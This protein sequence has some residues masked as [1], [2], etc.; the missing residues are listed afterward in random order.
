LELRLT[1]MPFVE[2]I[3]ADFKFR[4]RSV[5]RFILLAFFMIT[6]LFANE[7]EDKL[8]ADANRFYEQAEE[9]IRKGSHGDAAVLFKASLDMLKRLQY[10]YPT[11]NSVV[12][13]NRLNSCTQRVSDSEALILQSIQNLSK[14]E[15]ME[16][17]KTTQIA[18]AKFSKA[19]MILYDDLNRTKLE[20][21]TKN[22]SLTEAREAAGMRV[23]DKAHLDKLTFENL[24][25]RKSLRDK[26]VQ[27]LS[28]SSDDATVAVNAEVNAE[29]NE[30]ILKYKKLQK[31]FIDKENKLKLEKSNLAGK[32]KT[33]SLKL[34]SLR[35]KELGF[36]KNLAAMELLKDR[37]QTSSK[38]EKALVQKLQVE[39]K[40]S[41]EKLSLALSR[42]KSSKE[43]EAEMVNSITALKKNGGNS[44]MVANLTERNDELLK[45]NSELEKQSID[46]LAKARNLSNEYG[47]AE[48]ALKAQIEG[49]KSSSKENSLLK[50]KVKKSEAELK[51][52]SQAFRA[53]RQE[54]LSFSSD[55][56]SLQAQLKILQKI[57]DDYKSQVK[58]A[59]V[60]SKMTPSSDK[61]L[62]GAYEQ[63]VKE[64][65]SKIIFLEKQNRTLEKQ[66]I[67]LKEENISGDEQ[68]IRKYVQ[69]REELKVYKVNARKMYEQ[70][71]NQKGGIDSVIQAAMSKDE[72]AENGRLK[73][74]NDLLFRA[75]KQKDPEVAIG[76]YANALKLDKNNFDALLR[77]GFIS[78]EQRHF[79][80]AVIHLQKAFYQQPDHPQLLLALGISLIELDKLELAMSAL[81]RLVGKYPKDAQAH[82]QLGTVLQGLGWIEAAINHFNTAFKL[83]PQSAD[84]AFNLAISYLAL[85]E[86]NV[87]EARVFYKKAID[88]GIVK[89]PV[90]EKYFSGN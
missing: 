84:A 32:L 68:M 51:Q 79:H 1:S 17:L 24:K 28:L 44:K 76:L 41:S 52:L 55:V 43:R 35:E 48:Q 33:I 27:M 25:L 75:S 12:V 45:K 74:I 49:T 31:E 4:G 62:L 36:E 13:K 80:D 72:K 2:F 65:Q 5:L 16:S 39:S 30:E 23:T 19:M 10:D 60:T 14:E 88:L 67:L 77:I 18:K 9:Q 46:L 6:P 21:K 53:E 29:V 22:K 15:L 90:L 59:P 42:V 38:N 82:L 63:Q 70:L 26:E 8:W 64:S 11:W 86:P 56:K 87:E 37:W 61:K 50:N 34:A 3:V 54:K 71:K 47:K 78:Y 7:Q 83:D 66:N 85:Q 69:V 81:S 20:L 73:K 89:D 57:S 58:V 40:S